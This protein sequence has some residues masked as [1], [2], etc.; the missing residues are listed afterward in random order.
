[1]FLASI[2]LFIGVIYCLKK[3]ELILGISYLARCKSCG[4]R[5]SHSEGGG[6]LFFQL[7]CAT[8]GDALHMP[9]YAPQEI[10]APMSKS[11][12]RDY[13]KNKSHLWPRSGRTFNQHEEEILTL[14]FSHCGCGGNLYPEGHKRARMRCPEC[15]DSKIEREGVECLFD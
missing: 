5:W 13:V 8:C 3:E 2:F 9:R 10:P 7:L 14:L 6:V 15:A 1:M 11:A 4:C 12:L